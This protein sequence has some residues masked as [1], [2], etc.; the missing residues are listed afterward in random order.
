LLPTAFEPPLSLPFVVVPIS[1]ALGA[2]G[3][4]TEFRE[5]EIYKLVINRTARKQYGVE[6][7]LVCFL[8]HLNLQTGI[9][10]WA[11]RKICGSCSAYHINMSYG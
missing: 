3:F 4:P 11:M 9:S 6:G 7:T 8:L 10:F 1:W 2:R 5:F